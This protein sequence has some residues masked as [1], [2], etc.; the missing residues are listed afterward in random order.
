MGRA[1]CICGLEINFS[2]AGNV[3]QA[4]GWSFQS[5]RCNCWMQVSALWDELHTR[6]PWRAAISASN[7]SSFDR[8][9]DDVGGADPQYL[10]VIAI[11]TVLSLQ[12]THP[13]WTD[14]WTLSLVG[15]RVCV[16]PLRP[17]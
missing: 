15:L 10:A 12:L 3:L 1:A 7:L 11:N 13:P 5:S 8:D 6:R 9:G 4:A 14:C 16:I 2:A 17:R